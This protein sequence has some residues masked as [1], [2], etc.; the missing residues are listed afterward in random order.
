MAL[1]VA[2]HSVLCLRVTQKRLH[3]IVKCISFH[4]LHSSLLFFLLCAF[5]KCYSL[6]I[7]LFSFLS[8]TYMLLI[9]LHCFVIVLPL[10]CSKY[11]ITVSLNH[12]FGSELHFHFLP[13]SHTHTY[14]RW[15]IEEH[16]LQASN[17]NFSF[18]EMFAQN[19]IEPAFCFE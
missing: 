17:T 9:C 11:C 19:K 18:Y 6:L 15:V 3:T 2:L 10:L 4:F 5:V 13:L 1:I 16:R 8:N 14:T 12:I 7:L